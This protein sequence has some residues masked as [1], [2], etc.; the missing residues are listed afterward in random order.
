MAE[1]SSVTSL[2][3]RDVLRCLGISGTAGIA[4]CQGLNNTGEQ[5]EQRNTDNES[6][7]ID[8]TEPGRV[9][10]TNPGNETD[11][12]NGI[13]TGNESETDP[14]NKDGEDTADPEEL[15]L[16]VLLEPN[17]ENST[18]K[19]FFHP[20]EVALK[21]ESEGYEPRIELTGP[22]ETSLEP[23]DT[24]KPERVEPYELQLMVDGEPISEK[25]LTREDL[26][27]FFNYE[28][29]NERHRRAMKEVPGATGENDFYI[30]DVLSMKKLA[31]PQAFGQGP[32]SYFET[33]NEDAERLVFACNPQIC[34]SSVKGD[35]EAAKA[36]FE[37]YLRQATD[38]V[39]DIQGVETFIN[40]E[41]RGLGFVKRNLLVFG[42]PPEN[43]E[44][45]VERVL[46]DN[47]TL[48]DLEGFPE[49]VEDDL[50]LNVSQN[51]GRMPNYSDH[52]NIR[53]KVSLYVTRYVPEEHKI[54]E[55]VYGPNGE[56]GWEKKDN[57]SYPGQAVDYGVDELV[58]GWQGYK[59]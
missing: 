59:S 32:G 14:G 10:E 25:E 13:D 51:Y 41:T 23:G 29:N 27:D 36:E 31:S 4:G 44:D 47:G 28:G 35:V 30:N 57:V 38:K 3:R 58:S 33:S 8:E 48:Y 46:S 55:D 39:E 9:N 49:P 19:D 26:S 6:D 43:P 1:K 17:P 54:V 7:S 12:G 52:G 42:T 21:G 18:Y 22:E 37:E 56:G 50:V 15:D 11:T 24:W 16:N 40:Q 20:V 5:P 45:L 53:G 34:L 2:S